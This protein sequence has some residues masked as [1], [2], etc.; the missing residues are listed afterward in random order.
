MP[1]GNKWGLPAGKVAEGQAPLEA[2]KLKTFQ[3][4]ALK[5]ENE[6]LTHLGEFKFVNGDGDD[7]TFNAWVAS[8]PNGE[9]PEIELNTDGHDTYK[10]AK[11]EELVK[12]KDLMVGMYPVLYK[13]LNLPSS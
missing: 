9:N 8:L 11:P 10:W 7:I 6:K 2:A 4:V 1:D 3:E 13:F 5:F 12:E